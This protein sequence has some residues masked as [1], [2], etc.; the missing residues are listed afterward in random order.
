MDCPDEPVHVLVKVRIGTEL[1]SVLERELPEAGR[2][3]FRPRHGSSP[4]QNRNDGRTCRQRHLDL[5]SD[6]IGRIIEP[7][8]AIGIRGS[9]PGLP[10]DHHH[11]VAAVR[12]FRGGRSA[13]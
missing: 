11:D 1:H 10:D 5:N 12:V 6:R 13:H 3:L 2:K 8:L 7:A 9:E 4:Q